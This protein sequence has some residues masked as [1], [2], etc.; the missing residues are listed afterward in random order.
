MVIVGY[1]P[2]GQA[3]AALLG[4]RGL[5][6]AV[7]ERWHAIYPLPRAAHFDHE[8]MRIWQELGLADEI[9][10]DLFPVERY[11]WHGVD[12]EPIVEFELQAP[13]DSGWH[14]SYLFYQPYIEGAL[15]RLVRSLPT[16]D[17]R[18]GWRAER[19]DLDGDGAELCIRRDDDVATTLGARYVVGADGANSF[20]RESL[21]V[22]THE[23]GFRAKWLTLDV[24]PHPDAD[25][26]RL[27]EQPCQFCDPVRP[28]TMMRTGLTHRRWEFMLLHG[29]S[30]ADYAD[31]GRVWELLEPWLSPDEAELLRFAVYE[32]RAAHAETMR[33]GPA[34]LIGDAAH[35]MPPFLGQGMCSGIRDA[36]NLAWKL[37]L[38]VRGLAGDTLLDTFTSERRP[39]TEAL[40]GIS[41]TM[42]SVVCVSNPDH[43][44]GR[45]AAFR[46]GEF[47]PPPI[48]APPLGPGLSAGGRLSVQG[49][50][51][52]GGRRGRLDDVV[53]RG[54]VLIAD[55]HDPRALL[56]PDE[57]AF[58]ERL[59]AKLVQLGGDG[60]DA[61]A[62]ADG[63]M[64][65]WLRR[66]HLA[67]ALVRPDY[68][69]FGGAESAAEIPGLVSELQA[70]LDR[71]P[72]PA[73]Q[74]A[75]TK[76]ER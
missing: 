22:E 10:A 17:L 12:R 25:L 55:G 64:T 52:A 5:E 3:L 33:V 28:T 46:S 60:P 26:S 71:S 65:A 20:V 13:A 50:V 6:V 7:V 43:A 8:I 62:D 1:G 48:E 27:P 57:T 44:A 69:V 73:G 15:D 53:G 31:A 40:I 58:I 61:I 42:G 70:R 29:E 9:S 21:G 72:V 32:F 38:V 67:A 16:V 59:D 74:T 41:T 47:V 76:G 63:R 68:Y 39:H 51:V 49:E 45:D 30:Q 11:V 14:P 4:R 24:E 75:T 19:L 56:G 37:D 23:L 66:E 54:F 34:F 2:V 35:V 18:M 36:A